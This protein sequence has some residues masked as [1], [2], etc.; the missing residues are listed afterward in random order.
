MFGATRSLADRAE[1]LHSP[2]VNATPSP[3]L[4]TR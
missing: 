3:L 4:V 1:W 2:G